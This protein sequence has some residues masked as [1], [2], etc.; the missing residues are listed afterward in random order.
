ME[1][2]DQRLAAPFGQ[3]APL[4]AVL[5]ESGGEEAT[6][7][8]VARDRAVG[9]QPLGERRGCRSN[10]EGAAPARILPRGDR[11]AEAL[12]TLGGRVALVVVGLDRLPVVASRE[13]RVDGF[14]ESPSV[15]GH[16][17][18]AEPQA[19]R[20]L[21]STEALPEKLENPIPRHE[22]M[23]ASAPVGSPSLVAYTSRPQRRRPPILCGLV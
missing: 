5:L 10:R 2:H 13:A 4:T 22:H 1:R 11:A 23:F 3:P 20:D 6:L 7:Q 16:R 9:R 14:A 21:P 18:L 15:I 19:I 12:A 17:R 8:V